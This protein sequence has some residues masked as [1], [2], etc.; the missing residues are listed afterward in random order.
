MPTTAKHIGQQWRLIGIFDSD[1]AFMAAF[2]KEGGIKAPQMYLDTTTGK[3][4]LYDGVSITVLAN[5]VKPVAK[6]T[7]SKKK[8]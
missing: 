2:N 4:K 3:L 8:K 7:A 1:Q 6:K 5:S